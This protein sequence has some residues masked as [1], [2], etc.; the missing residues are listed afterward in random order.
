MDKRVIKP[1][2]IKSVSDLTAKPRFA[3]YMEPMS[4]GYQLH[5][6]T[7]QEDVVLTDEKIEDPDGWPEVMGY[8]EAEFSKEHFSK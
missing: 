2:V 1:E 8:I 6:L 5:R 4:G 3:Y 7:V